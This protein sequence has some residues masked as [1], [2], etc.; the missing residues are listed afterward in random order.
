MVFR[1][2][3]VIMILF[4][5]SSSPF[6]GQHRDPPQNVTIRAFVGYWSGNQCDA[7]W[8]SGAPRAT[9]M[10]NQEPNFRVM[11]KIYIWYRS[12]FKNFI[13]DQISLS[14]A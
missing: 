12:N 2:G 5:Y 6:R 7:S 11:K 3:P 14:L 9:K 8:T 10:K 1:K 13:T 4:E